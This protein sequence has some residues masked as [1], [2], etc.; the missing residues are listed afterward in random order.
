M[1][2]GPMRCQRA[3]TYIKRRDVLD[4]DICHGNWRQLFRIFGQKFPIVNWKPFETTTD[5]CGLGLGPNKVAPS[6]RLLQKISL[7]TDGHKCSLE[8]PFRC[9]ERDT[10]RLTQKLYM[11]QY[12]CQKK[13]VSGLY[14]P[15]PCQYLSQQSQ[16]QLVTPIMTRMTARRKKTRPERL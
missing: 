6:V 14:M 13:S 3:P 5:L 7:I 12:V 4:I 11:H 2:I 10:S 1:T 8:R 16:L 9:L 15:A